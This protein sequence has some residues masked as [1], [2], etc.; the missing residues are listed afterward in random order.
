M[1]VCVFVTQN[2]RIAYFQYK[3][4]VYEANK[5]T[6]GL[7]MERYPAVKTFPM[8]FNIFVS[9]IYIVMDVFL[10]KAEF[11]QVLGFRNIQTLVEP[12]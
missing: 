6:I 12:K 4:I 5:T 10:I 7:A 3:I 1:F 9:V 11:K 2:A 8:Y